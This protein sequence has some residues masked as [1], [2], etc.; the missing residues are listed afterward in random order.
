VREIV[1]SD[2]ALTLA[3]TAGVWEILWDGTFLMSSECRA[4]ERALG[5]LARGRT[6]VGGLGMGFTVRAALDASAAS[7]EVVEI[8]PAV[9]RWN[10]SLLAHVA[11][12]PLTDARVT[13]HVADVAAFVRGASGFDSILLDVDNGP[14]WTARPENDALYGDDALA[15]TVRALAPGGRFAV[16]SAQREPVFAARLGPHFADVEERAI[17]VEVAGRPSEDWLYVARKT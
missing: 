13:V 4:S 15:A 7:V 6:L 8:S 10:Q 16:W 17:P 3:R 14:S 11:G 1:E 5:A 12:R 9:V 2:G